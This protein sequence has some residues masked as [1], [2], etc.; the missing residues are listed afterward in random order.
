M[1]DRNSQTWTSIVALVE[2][3]LEADAR[4]L[5]KR[6]I[7]ER[8][9]DYLRGRMTALRAILALGAPAVSPPAELAVGN[10]YAV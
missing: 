4:A 2:R 7:P 10:T 5:E 3:G 1:I 9:A 8:D 6:G